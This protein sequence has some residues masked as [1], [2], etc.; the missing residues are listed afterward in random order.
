MGA[1]IQFRGSKAVIK[2]FE[3]YQD[4]QA[5][6]IFQA[7]NLLFK[8][9]GSDELE[10]VLKMLEPYGSEA[11]YQLKV[12]EEIDEPKR[13]KEKTECDGSFAF[14]LGSE[15]LFGGGSA[16]VRGLEERIKKMEGEKDEEEEKTIG[17][18]IGN[19]LLGLLEQPTELVQLIG[20]IK[21]M[22][23]PA[24]PQA[25]AAIG[26]VQTDFAPPVYSQPVP[27]VPVMQPQ[28]Q[29]QQTTMAKAKNT[30]EQK[31]LPADEV[32]G[33]VLTD[34]EK[35]NRLAA[36]VDT[37]EKADPDILQHLE[38]LASISAESPQVFKMLLTTLDNFKA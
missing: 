7:K 1:S 37:L 4:A 35:V 23:A 20:A 6:A 9:S 38:K 2:A 28:Q 10:S 18:K 34:E 5:W 12:Y 8:G 14:K 30:E 22:F 24:P 29:P 32:K 31:P 36:A 21:Q 19:A 33:S 11:I 15:E 26:R 13:I 3:N 17:G 16:Y 25:V 27:A